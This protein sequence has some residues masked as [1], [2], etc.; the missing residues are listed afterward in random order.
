[1][2]CATEIIWRSDKTNKWLLFNNNSYQLPLPAIQEKSKDKEIVK[3]DK[4]ELKTPFYFAKIK[5]ETKGSL[6]YTPKGYGIV[7][8]LKP[9]Q[10]TVKVSNEVH[11]FTKHEI[12]T[13]IPVGLTF[14]ASSG[15]REDKAVLPIHSTAKDIVERIESECESEALASRIFFMGKEINKSNETL[16]KMGVV[17]LS[18]FLIISAMGKPMTVSRFAY[19]YQGWG[20]SASS[21]DAISFTTSRDIRVIGFGIYTPDN[22]T[23]ATGTAKFI[24][25]NDVKGPVLY[26]REVNITKNLDNPE[27][28]VYKLMFNRPMKVKAG[29]SFSCCLELKSG[30]THYGSGGN[31]NPVGEGD[32]SFTIS[33]CVGSTNGTGPTSGQVPEIYY[34]V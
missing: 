22:D 25:G 32:V 10:I 33:D 23:A 7:Q 13:E 30:N 18:R 34:Y 20:Y 3:K 5:S 4:K 27:D 31:T 29:D 1:M 6:V 9:E 8:A 21:I 12:T 14:I 16:E 15:K 11:E 19:T 2:D 28:K 26:F 24:Q 17:P